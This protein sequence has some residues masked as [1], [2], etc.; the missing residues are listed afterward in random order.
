MILRIIFPDLPSMAIRVHDKSNTCAFDLRKP[1][2]AAIHGQKLA[3]RFS[4]DC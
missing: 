4:T 1:F 3:A 2:M